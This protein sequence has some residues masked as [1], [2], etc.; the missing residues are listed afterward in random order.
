MTRGRSGVVLTDGRGSARDL[1]YRD[2]T[3]EQMIEVRRREQKKAASI[4][5]FSAA[6]EPIVM[7]SGRT[8]EVPNRV[9]V[10]A[11]VVSVVVGT[12][13]QSRQD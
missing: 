1:L 13:A 4:G 12:I 5:E 3:D 6:E 7:R 8:A 2:F 11:A 9:R 10:Q